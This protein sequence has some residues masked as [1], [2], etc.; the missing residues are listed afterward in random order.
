MCSC[1]RAKTCEREDMASCLFKRKNTSFRGRGSL[2]K[3]PKGLQ[4]KP[5]RLDC[6]RI[7]FFSLCLLIKRIKL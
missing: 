7:F 2:G 1:E 5:L 3:K 6:A 4:S